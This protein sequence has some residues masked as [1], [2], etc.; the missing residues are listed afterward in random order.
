MRETLLAVIMLSGCT[1]THT[2]GELPEVE[3][4]Q[5]EQVC[6]E[7]FRVRTKSDEIRLECEIKLKGTFIF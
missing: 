3:F 4:P 7:K 5:M 6:T 2:D 1:I